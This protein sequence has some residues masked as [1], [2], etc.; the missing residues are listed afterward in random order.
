[1]IPDEL[2]LGQRER[3]TLFLTSNASRSGLIPIEGVEC[4]LYPDERANDALLRC[5]EGVWAVEG[6]DDVNDLALRG[7]LERRR[8]TVSWVAGAMTDGRETRVLVD[9]VQYPEGLTTPE[10]MQFGVDE[11]IVGDIGENFLQRRAAMPEVLQWLSE[12]LLLA[13]L[14]VDASYLVLSDLPGRREH[15]R[16]AFRIFGRT[17]AADVRADESGRLLVQRVVRGRRDRSDTDRGRTVLLRASASFVDAAIVTRFGGAMQESLDR[18][19]VGGASYLEFWAEYNRIEE[20]M[21]L[22]RARKFG[23]LS[24]TRSESLGDGR[25]RFFA[26]GDE[27]LASWSYHVQDEEDVELETAQSVPPELTADAGDPLL[28]ADEEAAERRRDRRRTRTFAGR[29]VGADL[30]RRSV[31]VQGRSD[32]D[33]QTVPPDRGVLFLSLVGSQRMIERRRNAERRI[34][35]GEAPM[36]MRLRALLEDVPVEDVRVRREQP[37]TPAVRH[38]LGGMPTD[39]QRDALDVAL[40]TPDIALVQG[41]PGTGKTALIAALQTRI[42][43]LADKRYTASGRMLLTSAQHDAVEHAA[44]RTEVFGLPPVKIGTRWGH[45][46][47]IDDRVERWRG[48]RID[49]ISA[50]LSARA[51]SPR[52][53]VLREVRALIEGYS[54]APG[55]TVETAHLLRR[56]ASAMEPHV[57]ADQCDALRER[58]RQLER[59]RTAAGSA[60]SEHRDLIE[61]A[62]RGLRTDPGTFADD[63]QVMARRAMLRLKDTA[64]VSDAE[65]GLLERAADWD[66][67]AVPP[68]L[69]ALAILR[70]HCLDA[71]AETESP[72]MQRTVDKQALER[73]R[74][75]ATTLA[76]KVQ[77]TADGVADV[78]AEFVH[79]LRHDPRGVERMLREY[80]VVL[81][82][83]C[84][85]AASHRFA[86]AKGVFDGVTSAPG[87]AVAIDTSFETV[88]IDEAAR[89]NP[90]DLLI[91]MSMGQRRIILVGDHRQLPHMLEPEVERE[92]EGSLHEA[93]RAALKQSLFERLFIALRK[94]EASDNVRRTVTLD[95]QF[96]MHPILGGFVSRTFYERHDPIAVIKA[97]R[98]AEDFAHD[99]PS[100]E[101]A[102]AAWVDVPLSRGAETRGQSRSRPLE[103]RITAEWVKRFADHRPDFSIGVV[104]FYSAQVAALW[105]AFARVGLAQRADG[106]GF[107]M[108]RGYRETR[109]SDGRRAERLRIG[110]VDSLQGKEFD[111]VFLSLTRSNDIIA[112]DERSRRRKYGFLML[113]NRLCVAMSRQQRLLVV[114][115]DSAMAEGPTAA[116]AVPALAAFRDLCRGT[117]GKLLA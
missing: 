62:V 77:H 22:R 60:E 54:V 109:A 29:F 26:P 74:A 45:E 10:V 79:D 15:Q 116:E 3:L 105:E 108:L 97:G 76:E 102:V 93:A 37:L 55:D 27:D 44:S 32:E 85:Q 14:Y 73:L 49:Q 63:G 92:L 6:V 31:D 86:E 47:L 64:L 99:L 115:G 33:E 103:A 34:V 112:N 12:E 66:S 81:A 41:P 50:D 2:P 68:F 39:R 56:V 83:T 52:L 106:G 16:A 46:S 72:A 94:R 65:L 7:V 48:E 90:L 91:P 89:A 96:R 42:A 5:G 18:L 13:A 71:L 25:W 117:Q 43:E 57:S 8:P 107:E 36:G 61:R 111:V 69:D 75:A 100:V 20:R 4:A 113:E 53:R 11:K 58:A 19:V 104:G 67:D 101:G 114:V 24:Y 28:D 23:W 30:G 80:T 17:I 51:D 98:P 9:L 82:A 84:Q 59:G 40:N 38:I 78:M 87:V 70:D 1:M 35:R 88:I 21:L 95:T 110:T